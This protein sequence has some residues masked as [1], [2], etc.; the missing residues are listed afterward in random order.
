M[1]REDALQPESDRKQRRGEMVV[2]SIILAVP[3]ATLPALAMGES[4]QAPALVSGIL[5]L[6]MLAVGGFSTSATLARLALLL[7]PFSIAVLA[8]PALWIT[9]QL[10]PLP[11]PLH[12]LANPIWATASGALNQPL[13]E[14][15]TV[16][17]PATMLA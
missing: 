14:R 11:A 2:R 17:V 6:A 16:D 8:V 3:A 1:R 13:A 10:V 9:L 5:A 4:L 15:F 7:R 12:G